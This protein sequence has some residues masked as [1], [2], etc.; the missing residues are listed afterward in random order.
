M[1]D[2]PRA[3]L[4]SSPTSGQPDTARTS[5]FVFAA[6][7]GFPEAI[8]SSQRKIL[9]SSGLNLMSIGPGEQT[10]SAKTLIDNL[11]P[12]LRHG[13]NLLMHIHGQLATNNQHKLMFKE[14]PES[15]V[16]TTNFLEQLLTQAEKLHT[17][18]RQTHTP[19]PILHVMSCEA[20]V[21]TDEILPHSPLWNSA[22]IILYS[23]SK[24]ILASHYDAALASAA[25]YMD[26]CA[27]HDIPVDPMRLFYL[28]GSRRGDGMRLLGGDLQTPLVLNA[29][30]IAGDLRPA[31]LG[32]RLKGSSND[33]ADF[34]LS[35]I[36]TSATE[37]Q[38]AAPWRQAIVE[39]LN[40]R[41]Q[42]RDLVGVK[43]LLAEQPASIH[44]PASA[45]V[46]PIVSALCWST[47]IN[48][49]AKMIVETILTK[50]VDLSQT[51]VTGY[52]P[53]LAA[54]GHKDPQLLK[55]LLLRGA[56]PNEKEWAGET[57]LLVATH[58]Q[59]HAGIELLLTFG[60]DVDYS[61]HGDTALKLAVRRG[62][63]IA[64]E[65]LLNHGAGPRAGLSQALIDQ[66][67]KA[68]DFDIAE[69]LETAL[70]RHQ[71]G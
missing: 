7:N 19:L 41:I 52:G 67:N 71:E 12:H 9:A 33:I 20:G 54:L 6:G 56:N 49:D 29:P 24:P 55:R 57:P 45:K 47:G 63:K 21:L 68:R 40:T 13:A 5:P 10:E 65:L 16:S 48:E 15:H 17:R 34:F 43:R 18:R 42:R 27:K 53:V 30:K 46:V 3:S 60:A 1:I 32:R 31:G 4:L 23:G 14:A 22:Y 69:M 11:A 2:L 39:L 50:C 8:L 28:A 70:Q 44:P 26:H 61:R 36:E 51:D 62:D 37:R 59:F 66:A 38:L 58:H 25:A 35:A 64:V